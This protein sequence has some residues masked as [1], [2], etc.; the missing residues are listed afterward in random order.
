[1]R[2]FGNPGTEESS[3]AQPPGAPLLRLAVGDAAV[4]DEAPH[5]PLGRGVDDLAGGE[6]HKVVVPLLAVVVPAL[7][8]AVRLLVEDLTA[9]GTGTR[10]EGRNGEMGRG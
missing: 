9:E 4:V 6:V 8:L 3:A 10:A 7:A 5:V 2:R 1:M